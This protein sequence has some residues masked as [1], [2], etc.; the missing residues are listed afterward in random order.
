[1]TQEEMQNELRRLLFVLMTGTREECREAKKE[2][3]TLWNRET[4]VFQ[5]SAEVALKFL[6]KF[7]QIENIVNKEA[8]ASGLNL[9]F[10]AL[11]DDHFEILKDF[12]LKVIQHENGH[13]REAIR[14]TAEWLY[15]SLTSRM[16]PFMYPKGKELTDKQKEEQ[17]KAREQ[18]EN[19][20]KN[21]E[22]LI[23]TYDTGDENA[24]YIDEMKPS[25][26]KSLQ[27]LW[28]RLTQ[29][30]AYQKLLKATRPIPPEIFI[31]RKQIEEELISMLKETES[32][33]SLQDVRDA[34][35]HEED[36]DD[37]MKVVSMF[38]RGGDASELSNILELVTDAW[39]YFP[40]K[41]LNGLSPAEKLSDR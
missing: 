7:D 35:F 33:F 34:I 8:F 18:Y 12:T 28:C 25:I 36:N 21:I 19:Y 6:P 23:D 38:D 16:D 37:M 26:N 9:F 20:V 4:K 1:M 17:T 3:R 32:I 31:K 41:I 11:G 22:A 5:S 27:Q 15:V 13:V 2:I 14:N 10:L 24:E 40:H 29:S 30:H 39:N